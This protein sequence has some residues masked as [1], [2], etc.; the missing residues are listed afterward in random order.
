MQPKPADQRGIALWTINRLLR[1]F[2]I[3]LV[4]CVACS[5]GEFSEVRI[6]I[7]SSRQYDKRARAAKAAK[8]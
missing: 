8:P 6:W 4:V 5:S 3:V 2:G 1:T 7:E